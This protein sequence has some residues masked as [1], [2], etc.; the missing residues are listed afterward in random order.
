M[1]FLI[2]GLGNIGKEYENTRHNI[3]FMVV[4]KLAKELDAN[5]SSDRFADSAEAKYR[6]KS[7]LILKPTTFMNLSGKAVKFHLDKHKIDI[8]NLMVITDDIALP[9]AKLRM[10][11]AGSGG[12][13]N[14]LKSIQEM[15]QTPNYPRLRFGVDSKFAKG[16]QADYV[17]ADFT[18]DEKID[19]SLHIDKCV[20]A[21]LSYIMEG[22]ERTMTK[23]N[24]G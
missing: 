3:G 15:L 20:Q 9:Y 22:L 10:R 4:D 12:G 14:G 8:A 2:V 11:P 19:L 6:G 5:F 13:H 16:R 23:V 7:L 21:I 1:K 24:A 17:L 18:D